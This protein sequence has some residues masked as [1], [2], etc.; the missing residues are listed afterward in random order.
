MCAFRFVSFR[1]RL[2]EEIRTR[3]LAQIEARRQQ[4]IKRTGQHDVKIAN[5]LK[6]RERDIAERQRVKAAKMEE[7]KQ[8]VRRN[9]NAAKHEK[10]KLD[11]KAKQARPEPVLALF[12]TSPKF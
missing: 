10:R 2:R 7:R 8:S 4:L 3:P 12:Q 5:M 9:L 11:V 1:V 6:H